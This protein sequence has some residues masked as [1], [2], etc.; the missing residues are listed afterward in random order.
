MNEFELDGIP[1]AHGC[2]VGY[3]AS[4]RVTFTIRGEVEDGADEVRGQIRC[5]R[6]DRLFWFRCDYPVGGKRPEVF[7]DD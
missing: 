2:M 7:V 3:P 4:Q 1:C 6:C 5:T